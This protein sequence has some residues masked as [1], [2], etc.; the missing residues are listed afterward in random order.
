MGLRTASGGGR[1]FMLGTCSNIRGQAE[2]GNDNSRIVEQA[3][4]PF[5]RQRKIRLSLSS[6]VRVRV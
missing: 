2:C 1:T 4:K 6:F 5:S 3:P